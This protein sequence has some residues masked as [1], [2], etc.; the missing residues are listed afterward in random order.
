MWSGY[1]QE[2]AEHERHLR[3]VAE[4]EGAAGVAVPARLQNVHGQH[5]GQAQGT[6]EDTF[7]KTTPFYYRTK[8]KHKFFYSHRLDLDNQ[9]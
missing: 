3:D 7:N 1:G 2:D 5:P 6:G 9:T 8:L 4:V